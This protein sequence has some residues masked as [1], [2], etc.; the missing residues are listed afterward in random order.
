M[1]SVWPFS[2]GFLLPPVILWAAGLGGWWNWLP[3]L[4]IYAGLPVA[5]ALARLNPVHHTPTETAELSARLSFR[6]VTWLWVPTQTA[7]VIWALQR[8]TSASMTRVEELG[9]IMSI[10]TIAGGIGITYAHELIHRP[11]RGELLLGDVLLA[12][13]TY[14]H[15]A[16]EH[17]YG[18]H[19]HVATPADPVTARKG[20]SFYRFLPRA[21]VGSLAHAW[22]IEAV[23]ADRNRRSRWSL[24][25]RMVRYVLTTAFIYA[26]VLNIWG[27]R[28][29]AFFAAQSLVGIVML[30]A[31]NY[32]EH[33]GLL[34]REIHPGEYERVSARH[35]WDSNHR[36]SNWL[37]INLARHSDHH[38]VASKRYQTLDSVDAS[39]QLPWGYGTMLLIAL[40][41]PVWRRVMDERCPAM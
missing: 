4:V 3:V 14:P 28:G 20:E 36:V 23:R 24:G 26:L 2:I 6:L 17:V 9:L 41:P 25:N 1:T 38:L 18:H 11:G 22:H 40:V 33:Y 10:G 39:P 32:V 21:I 31:I 7:L 27:V 35:S 15:F 8:F 5:D 30:E 16:I 37:L 29:L 13:V 34:R 19:R 12:L